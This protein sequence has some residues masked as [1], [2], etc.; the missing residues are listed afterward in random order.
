MRKRMR[1]RE[2]VGVDDE[3]VRNE[4]QIEP[5]R[6]TIGT[7]G[8][9]SRK[10]VLEFAVKYKNILLVVNSEPLFHLWF[11]KVCLQEFGQTF[12]TTQTSNEKC[13]AH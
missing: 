11:D 6:V 9:R 2:C 7:A 13:D 3:R 4:Q 5:R 8:E 10:N 1:K 12:L